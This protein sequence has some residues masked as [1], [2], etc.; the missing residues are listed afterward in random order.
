MSNNNEKYPLQNTWFCDLDCKLG[1]ANVGVFSDQD[2]RFD[3]I[4]KRHD[5]AG[6]KGFQQGIPPDSLAHGV[7]VSID[8][9]NESFCVTHSFRGE[10]NKHEADNCKWVQWNEKTHNPAWYKAQ[11]RNE[12]FT[13]QSTIGE[14]RTKKQVLDYKIKTLRPITF[15]K[16]DNKKMILVYL[17]T[18]KTVEKIRDVNDEEIILSSEIKFVN[19][20]YF[21]TSKNDSDGEEIREIL[22]F[23]D[24]TLKESY[25]INVLPEWEGR[26][27]WDILDCKKWVNEKNIQSDPKELYDLLDKTAKKYLEYN[28]IEYVK[29]NLWGIATYFYE[30]FPAFPYYDF[31]GTKRAGKTKS[32]EFQKQICY[33]AIMSS[34]VTGSSLFRITEG[35]GATILLDETEEFKNKKNEQAQTVRNLLMQGFLKDQYA[36]RSDT[37]KDKNFTPTQYNIF[38][39]KS[40]AHINSFDDVLEDRCLRQTMKRALNQNIINTNISENDPS[41]Q[42]IRNKCYKL[43]LEY[44]DQIYDLQEEATTKLGITGRE[45][46]LWIP[47]MTLAVFF[48]KFGVEGGLVE[49]VLENMKKSKEDRQLSDEESSKDLKVLD[50]LDKFGIELALNEKNDRA[51]NPKGWIA[52]QPLYNSFKMVMDDTYQINPEYFTRRT[53]SQTLDRFG[54]TKQKHQDGIS[55]LITE[56]TVNEVKLRMGIVEYSES[57][58]N[59]IDSYSE[60]KGSFSSFSSEIVTNLP[61]IIKNEKFRNNTESSDSSE[62]IIKSSDGKYQTRRKSEVNEVNEVKTVNGDMGTLVL[63]NSELMNKLN[64][65]NTSKSSDS[66]EKQQ[67]K[68]IKCNSCNTEWNTNDSLEKIQT[69]HSTQYPD[70]TISYVEKKE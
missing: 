45:L 67:F 12:K 69:N 59:N 9:I 7:R 2:P 47:I 28:N 15:F 43:F 5:D 49:N 66:S 27:R 26:I 68:K 4:R 30:L 25:R 37:T 41:F 10:K 58:S 38:S 56:T 39:P 54:F 63:N 53:L 29:F 16:E 13:F 46:Q 8:G 52:L 6:C 22:P 50:Y 11:S 33:N 17:P 70:H 20:A 60:K 18:R 14:K 24:D 55:F 3:E 40:L 61:Q 34:N 44:A 19:S 32:L 31:T 36:I 1:A 23:D 57:N 21:L 51:K 35:I 64:I 62:N 65:D 48:E 42:V